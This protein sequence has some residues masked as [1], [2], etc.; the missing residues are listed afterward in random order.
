EGHHRLPDA[1]VAEGVLLFG[2]VQRAR[3]AGAEG[4]RV[5]GW[6]VVPVNPEACGEHALRSLPRIEQVFVTAPGDMN[7]DVF[8]RRLFVAR[9][10]AEIRLEA[11]DPAFYV[12]SLSPDTM[13]YKG[14]VMPAFLPTFYPD[15]ADPRLKSRVCVF[16]Q[17][18]STN[19]LPEW[20]LAQPFRF[21]AHNG[22][23]NTIQGNRNWAV[24]RAGK[25]RS[26]VLP[27]LATLTPLVNM[28]G[29]D[30]SSLDNMLELMVAAGMD[31]MQALRLL[32]PPA[33]Q[34]VDDF[35]PDVRAFYEY[36]GMHLEPWDGPA[37]VVFS[38]GRNAGCILD[39]NGLRPAR[40]V[41]TDDD[42]L[43]IASEIGVW[44][45]KPEQVVAKGRLGPGEMI[46]ADTSNGEILEWR[47]IDERLA[48]RAPYKEWLRR[49]V[50]Y[51]ETELVDPQLLAEPMD[52]EELER[53]EKMFGVTRE[54]RD[55]VIR[56]LCEAEAEA[57]GSMGDDTP[58]PFMSRRVRSLYDYFR[59][60]FAQVTNPPIDP[61]RERI[62]MSL[63][64]QIGPEHHPNLFVGDGLLG[65]PDPI[66]PNIL[67]YDKGAWLL[68]ALRLLM[69]D[70]A[71][72]GLLLDY[73]NDPA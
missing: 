25:F 4:L 18:F 16:H 50:K 27:E 26:E 45:Y 68:H 48:R 28:A 23:I 40:W 64:T 44:D 21:L 37:G 47:E 38:D 41:V 32:I 22:E 20:R 42:H 66:L 39:R 35:D 2:W 59:Q 13:S 29:S 9:R 54:E 52:R 71:F 73:A 34:T 33:W 12:A 5:D 46:I 30:S 62:V 36:F 14:M 17:R 7:A 60:Q 55:E 57:V 67:V 70:E 31:V 53:Y 58:L 1:R 6:R 51:L 61:L 3:E 15:L 8:R 56:P 49:G 65:D 69:G 24:A 11:N 10:R 19:T 72:F 43:T 63:E